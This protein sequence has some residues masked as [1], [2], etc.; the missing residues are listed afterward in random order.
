M[1][2]PSATQ[3]RKFTFRPRP[4]SAAT[5]ADP[6][7]FITTNDQVPLLAGQVSD[8]VRSGRLRRPERL[9]GG[10]PGRCTAGAG[11]VVLGERP[12]PAVHVHID[13][14]VVRDA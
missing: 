8:T 7:A 5:P 13:D 9:R 2:S 12:L 10:W 14:F 3:P 6:S 11:A 4:R 1:S